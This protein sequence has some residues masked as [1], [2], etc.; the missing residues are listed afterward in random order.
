MAFEKV[1]GQKFVSLEVGQEFVGTLRKINEGDYGPEWEFDVDGKTVTLG[2]KTVLANRIKEEHI[3]K[4]MK[5]VRL[6]DEPSPTRKG[7]YYQNFDVF[8]DK[9]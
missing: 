6:A 5:I 1:E 8:I 7:K 4:R 2:N 3:G 9:P